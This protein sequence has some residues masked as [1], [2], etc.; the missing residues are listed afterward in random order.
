MEYI[1]SYFNIKSRCI[2]CASALLLFMLSCS[3]IADQLNIP[4]SIE[5]AWQSSAGQIVKH[6]DN[7]HFQFE[8]TSPKKIEIKLENKAS[9]KCLTDPYLYLIAEDGTLLEENDD[10]YGQSVSSNCN[11]DSKITRRLEPGKYTLVAATY[12]KQDEGDFVLS[13]SEIKDKNNKCYGKWNPSAGQAFEDTQNPRKILRLQQSGTITIDLKSSVDTYLYLLDPSGN[14]IKQDDDGGDGRNSRIIFNTAGPLKAG[15]Y[16]LVAATYYNNQRGDFE[17]SVAFDESDQSSQLICELP[18]Y[19]APNQ[20]ISNSPI[21][22]INFE[23]GADISKTYANRP[24]RQIASGG[25]GNGIISYSSSDEEIATVDDSGLVTIRGVGTTSITASKAADS[26]SNYLAAQDNY[27]LRVG[28]TP[29]AIGFG[30]NGSADR[31][32]VEH[33]YAANYSFDSPEIYSYSL[34]SDGIV[35]TSGSGAVT[36]SSLNPNIASVDRLSGRITVQGAGTTRINAVKAADNNYHEARAYYTLTVNKATQTIAFAEGN[37]NREYGN[38]PFS[39]TVQGDLGTGALTYSS[40]NPRIASVD[41]QGMVTIL[42]A[43]TTQITASKVADSNYYG[44]SASYTITVNKASQKIQVAYE[45]LGGNEVKINVIGRVGTGKL[46]FHSSDESIVTVD[47][48]GKMA[49]K[50]VSGGNATITITKAADANYK[51]SILS[52]VNSYKATRPRTPSVSFNTNTQGWNWQSGTGFGVEGIGKYR[53]QI[54]SESENGWSDLIYENYYFADLVSAGIQTLYVQERDAAGNW[55]KSGKSQAQIAKITVLDRNGDVIPPYSTTKEH[56]FTVKVDI[57]P[58]KIRSM[59]KKYSLFYARL[60][61]T[62]FRYQ[63]RIGYSNGVYSQDFVVKNVGQPVK[64]ELSDLRYE[65]NV[66]K[67]TLLSEILPKFTVT[68]PSGNEIKPNSTTKHKTVWVELNPGYKFP[69]HLELSGIDQ[70]DIQIFNLELTNKNLSEYNLA[71]RQNMKFQVSAL[72]LGPVKISLPANLYYHNRLRPGNLATT[73]TWNYNLSDELDAQQQTIDLKVMPDRDESTVKGT[74]STVNVYSNNLI[75]SIETK[76]TSGTL[77]LDN[78]HGNFTYKLSPANYSLSKSTSDWFSIKVQDAKNGKNST[79]RVDI[80]FKDDPFFEQQ[81]HTSERSPILLFNYPKD[82]TTYKTSHITPS[83]VINPAI[84]KGYTGKGVTVAIVGDGLDLEHRD[85]KDNLVD[86]GSWDFVDNDDNPG[87]NSNGKKVGNHSTKVAAVLGAVGW[88]NIGFRG[89]APG[90]SIKGFRIFSNNNISLADENMANGYHQRARDVDIINMSYHENRQYITKLH[91]TRDFN[92]WRNSALKQEKRVFIRPSGNG[93]RKL[94]LPGGRQKECPLASEYKLP[95]ETT[96]MDPIADHPLIINVAAVNPNAKADIDSTQ[97][98]ANW[99]SAP[100]GSYVA[101]ENCWHLAECK[102]KNYEW[103]TSFSAG[104]VSGVVALMLEANPELTWRDVKHILAKT[105][106][107]IDHGNQQKYPLIDINGVR[108]E[109]GWRTNDA[110]FTFHNAYGF[111]LING[112]NAIKMAEDYKIGQ[113]GKFKKYSHIYSGPLEWDL[114]PNTDYGDTLNQSDSGTVEAV[115]VEMHLKTEHFSDLSI[116]LVSPSGTRS[117]LMTPF[118]GIE[119]IPPVTP[120]NF[121]GYRKEGSYI[122]LSSNA[123]YGEPLKGDWKIEVYDHVV[124]PN[125]QGREITSNSVTRLNYW[126]LKLY[127]HDKK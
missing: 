118:N 75:Y 89:V 103:G 18:N 120:T 21:A 24:F 65:F 121:Y 37:Q 62:Q 108:V 83:L 99:I 29:Q 4:D 67:D 86:G 40:N 41:N 66:H 110:G 5:G 28:K 124:N 47:S 96:T 71:L 15:D 33:D 85:L 72:K 60:E 57:G 45:I 112:K 127:G 69:S 93:F 80:N 125:K 63:S 16:S 111:G 74:L 100:N 109:E 76:P 53:Y 115:R 114:K 81:W 26:D 20:P 77:E 84:N 14:M 123:F 73:F 12:K 106:L 113:L 8:L 34:T 43:G 55:S 38:T 23:A 61:N 88:N 102:D 1:N 17:L 32:Q 42:G 95:C 54:N 64:I 116:A 48:A 58:K 49:Y 56:R 119:I 39:Q 68:D 126:K 3:S 92:F 25:S 7:P 46:S 90:V 97:G 117:V 2:G 105:A 107:Q 22:Q 13:I 101:R 35:Y 44:A 9:N 104:M 122:E 98:A 27:Q 51:E 70:N 78:N 59:E 82:D 19:S 36:Y 91:K 79:A 6:I 52:I 31:H 11:Y 30:A 87:F 10:R 94:T 50:S